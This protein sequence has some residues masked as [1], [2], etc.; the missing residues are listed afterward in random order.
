MLPSLLKI[1]TRERQIC[2]DSL[3]ERTTETSLDHNVSNYGG[4]VQRGLWQQQ[5]RATGMDGVAVG[6]W[7]LA[8]VVCGNGLR[9]RR[10]LL[11]ASAGGDGDGG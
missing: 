6:R 5:C 8:Y 2:C 7:P 4:E 11:L 3:N 9:Q 10:W 1:F